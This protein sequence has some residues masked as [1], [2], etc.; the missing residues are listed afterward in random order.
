MIILI[1]LLGFVAIAGGFAL[2]W[3]FSILA[4]LL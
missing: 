2:I 1:P 3:I 4:G